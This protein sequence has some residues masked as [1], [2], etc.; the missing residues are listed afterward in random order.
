MDSRG[1]RRARI[2]VA[3]AG[4]LVRLLLGFLAGTAGV[5]LVALG[6]VLMLT[7]VLSVFGLFLA[8]LGAALIVAGVQVSQGRVAVARR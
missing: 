4:I 2:A 1:R 3:I 5:M 6:C 7:V 8:Q